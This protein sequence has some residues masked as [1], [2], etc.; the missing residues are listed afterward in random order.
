M[1]IYYI[2]KCVAY[3]MFLLPIVAIFRQLCFE[4]HSSRPKVVGSY[5]DRNKSN[6]L[7]VHCWLYLIRN[8]DKYS[9]L[10]LTR[11]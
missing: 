7:Y 8:H 4:C 9:S 5:S 10:S 6:N 11:A 3:Y 1:Y 2:K